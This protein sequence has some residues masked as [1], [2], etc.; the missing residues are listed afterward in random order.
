MTVDEGRRELLLRQIE[1]KILRG[2]LAPVEQQMLALTQAMLA[3]GHTL[4]DVKPLLDAQV[5]EILE[6]A[7]VVAA[8]ILDAMLAAD[9]APETV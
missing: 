7:P 6:W 1:A 9:R 8:Q 3:D 2:L 4:D 5:R